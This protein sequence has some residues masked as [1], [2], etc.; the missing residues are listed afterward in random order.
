VATSNNNNQPCRSVVLGANGYIGRHLA[1]HLL[2]Q[3]HQVEGF[4]LHPPDRH[5]D[6]PCHAFDATVADQWEALDT[7]V[8]AIYF[9]SGM[10]GTHQGFTHYARYLTANELSLMHL[11]DLLRR[12]GHR[13]RVVFPSSRL[14][15]RGRTEPLD[16]NAPQESKTVYSANK[17]AGEA[18]LQA[19]RAAFG[20]PF[21]IYRICVPYGHLH[22]GAYSF[23]TIG[24]FIRMA[25]EQHAITLYGGGSIRRTF[26]HVQ[27]V[28][29]QIEST[30]RLPETE[31]QAFNVAGEPF[32]LAQVAGWIAERLDARVVPADWPDKEWA[33]ESG[34]TVFED[35]KIRAVLPSPLRFHLR[36]WIAATDFTP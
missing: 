2:S 36:D 21:T 12:R 26:T 20:I 14:V 24:A 7:H 34:D 27:D 35:T 23:G 1:M 32:S 3:G 25:K 31:G 5:P 28:C 15:Y 33:I 16:E 6:F 11:L 19:Y 18:F 4:D 22:G 17:R 10:T 29:A 13:P 9:F 8:D 30:A